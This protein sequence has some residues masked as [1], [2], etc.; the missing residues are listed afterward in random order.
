[1]ID[2]CQTFSTISHVRLFDTVIIDLTNFWCIIY[3]MIGRI[4]GGNEERIKLK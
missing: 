3:L 1:M 4:E 2:R